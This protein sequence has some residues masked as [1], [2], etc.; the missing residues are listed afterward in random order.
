[1]NGLKEGKEIREREE[2]SVHIYSLVRPFLLNIF[3]RNSDISVI[4]KEDVRKK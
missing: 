3:S 4:C 1:M 2:T